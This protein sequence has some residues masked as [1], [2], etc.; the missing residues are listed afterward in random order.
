L[1][2]RVAPAQRQA[3][4]SPLLRTNEEGGV[5]G[6]A[7]PQN[8]IVI[9]FS[10]QDRYLADSLCKHFGHGHVHPVKDKKAF[11]W[12]ISDQAGALKFIKLI[13][14]HLR[15]QRKLDQVISNMANILPLLQLP[16]S[17]Q[18]QVDT[19]CLS[20]SWWLTGLAETDGSFYIHIVPP[21]LAA[22]G[23]T[24]SIR[25]TEVRLQF[26]LLTPPCFAFYFLPRTAAV[27]GRA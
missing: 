13:N 14:G 9:V 26:K 24:G 11:T 27:R 10:E 8:Q 3:L 17:Y 16:H 5:D 12:V 1:G 2:R 21:R 4:T 23:L 15:I 25:K 18:S 7:S 20:S 6:Y 19:S 22:R